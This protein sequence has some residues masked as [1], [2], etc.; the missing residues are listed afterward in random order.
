MHR[1]NEE[2]ELLVHDPEHET[3][4]CVLMNKSNVGAD[5]E[6]GRVEVHHPLIT[7]Q[8]L[9]YSTFVLTLGDMKCVL[10]SDHTRFATWRPE[11]F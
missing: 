11:V 3:L 4:T 9:Y 1:W 7:E 10:S 8:F 6:I 5:E 2:F